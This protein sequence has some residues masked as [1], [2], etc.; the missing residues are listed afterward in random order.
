MCSIQ[1]TDRDFLGTLRHI[2]VV[3]EAISRQLALER[4]VLLLVKRLDL[5]L[6]VLLCHM[7]PLLLLSDAF[8]QLSLMG[9]LAVFVLD[10]VVML[11]WLDENR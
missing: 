8:E 10:H 1:L 2:T 6:W 4:S 11:A 5:S 9:I 7:V 3:H